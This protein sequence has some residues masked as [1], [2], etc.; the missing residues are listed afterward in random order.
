MKRKGKVVHDGN[1]EK[2]R[3]DSQNDECRENGKM[4]GMMIEIKIVRMFSILDSNFMQYRIVQKL[5]FEFFA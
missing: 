3:V 5:S 1:G 2:V 4:I